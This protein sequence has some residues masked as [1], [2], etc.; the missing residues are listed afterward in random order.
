LSLGEFPHQLIDL[1]KGGRQLCQ[2]LWVGKAS[3]RSNAAQSGTLTGQRPHSRKRGER[4]SEQCDTSGTMHDL[5]W[6]F[7]TAHIMRMSEGGRNES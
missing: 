2:P 4:A 6:V 7:W 3:G 5:S 1:R